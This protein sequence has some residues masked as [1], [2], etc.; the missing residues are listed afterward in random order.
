MH[1]S[2]INKLYNIKIIIQIY[3]LYDYFHFKFIAL[4]IIFNSNINENN[5]GNNYK[6]DTYIYIKKEFTKNDSF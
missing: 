2:I 1:N 3:D 4:T 5:N 6:F